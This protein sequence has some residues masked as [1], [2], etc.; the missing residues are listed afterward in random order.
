VKRLGERL[1]PELFAVGVYEANLAG[2]DAVVD[3]RVVVGGCS[4]Y[5]ASLLERE[6]GGWPTIGNHGHNKKAGVRK[7]RLPK[8]T[9][10]ARQ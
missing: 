2:P 3:P 9:R 10:R 8:R 1:D 5:R 4:G 6:A 7:Q